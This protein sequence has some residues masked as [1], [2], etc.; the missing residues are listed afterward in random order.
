MSNH[1]YTSC[2]AQFTSATDPS[3]WSQLCFTPE[4]ALRAKQQ[5]LYTPEEKRRR[6]AT[7]WTLVQGILAPLQFLVFLISLGLVSRY[8]ATGEGLWLATASVVLKTALLY[9]IM[10][11]GSI[12]ERV[13]FGRY[14]FA[15]AFFW[16]DVFSM[17]VIALHT[18][19]LAAII[20]HIGSARQQMLLVLAAY[21]SYAIN[22]AQFLLKLRAAR[23]QD[24]AMAQAG[25]ER[26][27]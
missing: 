21:A 27:S 14:L 23:L 9:T 4:P 2:D 18:A 8:L 5:P 26:V 15:P 3:L 19:Y 22:A 11:T 17:L 7:P 6:D 1:L 12:W 13:V 10:I 16:E 25:A 20:G 24:Q